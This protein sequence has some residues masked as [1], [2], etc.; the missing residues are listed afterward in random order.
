MYSGKLLIYIILSILQA[1]VTLIGAHLLGV[2]IANY[3]L[4]IVSA[5][6]VSVVFM[7]LIYSIISAIGTVGKGVAVILL[8]F[9][10]SGTG[11]IYPIQIMPDLFQTLHHYLPMTYAISLVRKHNSAWF[12]QITGLL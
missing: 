12:G 3:P 2:Y 11:G 10:I 6:L 4:F 1:T 8:V 9:Q 7:I 5:I